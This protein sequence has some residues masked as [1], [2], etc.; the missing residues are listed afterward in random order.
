MI[1]G[2]ILSSTTGDPGVLGSMGIMAAK[3]NCLLKGGRTPDKL[4]D[5]MSF[6]SY[7]KAFKPARTKFDWLSR[8]PKVVDDYINDDRCGMICSSKFF[9][10]MLK[11]LKR[12]H[13]KKNISGIP[14]DLPI[15]VIAGEKDPLGKG[16][17]GARRVMKA[18]GRH[19][20]RDI[21]SRFYRDGRHE[22]LNE[23]NKEEVYSDIM[24][25]IGSRPGQ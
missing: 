16:T 10:D 13:R 12:I 7:N 18:Y 14:R 22:M 1:D 15:L 5:R 6:G 3:I 25:W 2:L 20:I 4:L 11:G 24:D 8:D 19:G 21:S 23:I 17:R 9:L